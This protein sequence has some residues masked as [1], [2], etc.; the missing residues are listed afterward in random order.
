[1]KRNIPLHLWHMLAVGGKLVPSPVTA[2]SSC[3]PVPAAAARSYGV[4]QSGQGPL[5]S[6]THNQVCTFGTRSRTASQCSAKAPW[7]TTA[8]ASALSHR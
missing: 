1:M 3:R 5:P 6:S 8:V 2:M 7:N 4:A